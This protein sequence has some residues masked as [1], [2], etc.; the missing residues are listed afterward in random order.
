MTTQPH[1]S[2]LRTTFHRDVDRLEQ[3]LQAMGDLARI[4]LAGRPVR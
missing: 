3:D 2:E 4:A 1:R